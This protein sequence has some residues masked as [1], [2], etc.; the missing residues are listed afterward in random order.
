MIEKQKRP[1]SFVS[2]CFEWQMVDWGVVSFLSIFAQE[3]CAHP[4]G[5]QHSICNK[6]SSQPQREFEQNL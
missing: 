3:G 6:K 5:D 2:L 1:Q 4:Q